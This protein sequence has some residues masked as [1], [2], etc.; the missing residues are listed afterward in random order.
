M[1][2]LHDLLDREVEKQHRDW[3]ETLQ[4]LTITEKTVTRSFA[5]RSRDVER[6]F[7]SIV[8]QLVKSTPKDV[9]LR[10]SYVEHQ[11]LTSTWPA[12]GVSVELESK[13]ARKVQFVDAKKE[14][15][16]CSDCSSG[17]EA[18]SG[19]SGSIMPGQNHLSGESVP[20]RPRNRMLS[21][22]LRNLKTKSE[23][24]Y[25][26]SISSSDGFKSQTKGNVSETTSI[27]TQQK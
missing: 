17:D 24:D 18:L 27:R 4:R 14:Y 22:E 12:Q 6:N 11:Q 13:V 15:E 20:M 16:P 3:M 9:L 5:I 23:C 8:N 2:K 21:G 25:A 26:G 10:T 7:R 19:K 1:R